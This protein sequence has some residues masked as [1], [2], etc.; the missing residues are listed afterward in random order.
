MPTINNQGQKTGRL[1]R[2]RMYNNNI[3]VHIRFQGINI[4]PGT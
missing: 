3:T 1:K 2:M 4:E